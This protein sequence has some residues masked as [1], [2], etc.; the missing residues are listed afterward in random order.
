[1]Q[2][3]QG[4][5][6]IA[7]DAVLG[8]HRGT[9]DAQRGRKHADEEAEDQRADVLP[10]VFWDEASEPDDVPDACTWLTTRS[11]VAAAMPA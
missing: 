9:P 3:G 4:T 8:F 7:S 1:M 5:H 10:V 11:G 6:S 2:W